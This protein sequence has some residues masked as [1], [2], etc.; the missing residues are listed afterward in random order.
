M[1][2]LPFL[3]SLETH[4]LQFWG[5]THGCVLSWGLRLRGAH[6]SDVKGAACCGEANP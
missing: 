3:P 6:R 2:D 4:S 5:E 1:Q